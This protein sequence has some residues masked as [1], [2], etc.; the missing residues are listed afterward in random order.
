MKAGGGLASTILARARDW[1]DRDGDGV[2]SHFG[3]NDCDE[4]DPTVHPG[5][6]EI[7][8]D[9][10]DQDCD[11]IDPPEAAA[12]PSSRRGRRARHPPATAGPTLP[13]SLV[14]GARPARQQPDIVAGHARHRARRSHLGVRLRARPTTPR[15][16]ELGR[17]RGCLFE[18]AYAAGARPAARARAH[19][20]GQVPRRH[21]AG[22]ARVADAPPR[23][24][25]ARRAAQAGRLPHGGGHLVHV[26]ERGAGVRPGLR[27][28]EARLRGRPPRA[29]G[30]RPPRGQGGPRRV[31]GARDGPPPHLPLGPPLRRPRALPRAPRDP[32]QEQDRG[33]TTG[34]SPS[35]TGS[36]ASW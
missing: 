30:H 27:L 34:R 32:L 21:P 12:V 16:A 14:G 5:A 10:I 25:H 22:Q 24:R 11:G 7:P 36:S 31:E 9:G 35:S 23:Q 13:A 2:G 17:A 19:R 33:S 15:L 18:H 20:H 1:T 4:G 3:G 26:A 28:L 29:R 8:G 6:A